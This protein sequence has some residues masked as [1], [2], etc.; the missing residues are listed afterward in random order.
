MNPDLPLWLQSALVAPPGG[1]GGASF[2]SPGMGAPGVAAPMSILPPAG[3]GATA[4]P[5]SGAASPYSPA[6]VV[7][8]LNPAQ[9]TPSGQPQDGNNTPNPAQNPNGQGGGINNQINSFGNQVGKLLGQTVQGQGPIY[10]GISNLFG[11]GD[12][13]LG[14]AAAG[15]IDPAAF[16]AGGF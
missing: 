9:S 11:G 16:L 13:A 3:T 6:A 10:Q 14:T 15:S 8:A 4:S 12:A 5:Y 1:V 7:Q 2:G